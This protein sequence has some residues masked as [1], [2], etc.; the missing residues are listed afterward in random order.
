M[1][2]LVALIPISYPSDYMYVCVCV[3]VCVCVYEF[4]Y[5]YVSMS[6]GDQTEFENQICHC[7]LD[8]VTTPLLTQ[9][10]HL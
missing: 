3:C 6:F 5:A 10:F 7:V 8:Q 2:I 9:C 4:T 1:K